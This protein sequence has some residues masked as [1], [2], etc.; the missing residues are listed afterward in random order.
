MYIEPSFVQVNLAIV[1]IDVRVGMYFGSLSP[2]CG[3]FGDIRVS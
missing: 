2:S 3:H 1:F